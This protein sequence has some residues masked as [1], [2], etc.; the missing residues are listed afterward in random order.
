MIKIK[1]DFFHG[2]A[3]VCICTI[4]LT[5]CISVCGCRG[6]KP[7]QPDRPTPTPKPH[8]Q[9]VITANGHTIY[10]NGTPVQFKGL[11]LYFIWE[12]Q[13]TDDYLNDLFLYLQSYKFN[14]IRVFAISTFQKS[15]LESMGVPTWQIFNKN[16]NG[17]YDLN[18]IN[19]D[20]LTYIRRFTEIAGTYGITVMVVESDICGFKQ[21]GT[22]EYGWNTS[23]FN[24]RNNVNG[25]YDYSGSQYFKFY[26]VDYKPDKYPGLCELW[27]SV[28]RQTV[29]A[30]CHQGNVIWEIGNELSQESSHEPYQWLQNFMGHIHDWTVSQYQNSGSPHIPVF[31]NSDEYAYFWGTNKV[32]LQWSHSHLETTS[33][34]GVSTDGCRSNQFGTVNDFKNIATNHRN[35]G[36]HF[37]MHMAFMSTY[38][39]W[40]PGDMTGMIWD[41]EP[42]V[43]PSVHWEAHLKPYFEVI[44]NL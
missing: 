24:Y 30:L 19:T 15:R 5:L 22:D 1:Q 14:M 16:A 8:E 21:Y 23:A 35:R 9:T 17:K 33:F 6:D 27:E 13:L 28:I 44:K 41:T 18:S 26:R 36:K 38:I 20:W 25:K 34:N 3:L 11:G 42:L 43:N 12:R 31:A 10:K 29:N 7:D 32:N 2:L 37:E 39:G 40:Q 4:I